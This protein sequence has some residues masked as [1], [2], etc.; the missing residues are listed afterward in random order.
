MSRHRFDPLSFTFGL[1]FAAAALLLNLDTYL[2]VPG[3]RW[4]VAA[5]LVLLGVLLIA[6]SRKTRGPDA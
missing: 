4:L 6:T 2:A 1:F 5:A 3:L